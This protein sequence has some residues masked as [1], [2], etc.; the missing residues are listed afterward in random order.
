MKKE[1]VKTTKAS[2]KP[3]PENVF[4]PVG[5]EDGSGLYTLERDNLLGNGLYY[6]LYTLGLDVYSK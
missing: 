2:P 6:S 4:S 1:M 3:S 5:M